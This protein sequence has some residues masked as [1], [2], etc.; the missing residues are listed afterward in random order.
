[1]SFSPGNFDFYA[2]IEPSA[3]DVV[4]HV[5][6]KTLQAQGK[7]L[8]Q[9]TVTVGP[10]TGTIQFEIVKISVPSVGSLNLLDRFAPGN[11]IATFQA[12]AEI[13]FAVSFL[14]VTLNIPNETINVK[15]KDLQI[16]LY[17]AGGFLSGV[18]LG[19]QRF[20][21]D[22]GGLTLLRALNPV[23]NLLADFVALAI[24]TALTPLGMI[25]IPI[26]PLAD[27]YRKIGMLFDANGSPFL[28]T[29]AAGNGLFFA[30][31]F[32]AANNT[33]G[34]I[35]AVQD[36]LPPGGAM[37]VGAVVA[38]RLVNQLFAMLLSTNQVP[39]ALPTP[40]G[41]FRVQW[42]T[43]AF[44][45]PGARASKV[46]LRAK[47][48]ARK[49][50]G[51]GGFIGGLFGL[52]K[53]VT[54][55]LELRLTV[56]AGVVQPAGVPARVDFNFEAIVRGRVTI[57]S[58]LIGVLT[59]LMGPFIAIFLFVLSQIL[60]FFIDFFL[61]F[62]FTYQTTTVPGAPPTKWFHVTIDKLAIQLGL[63]T[64]SLTS[65]TL[66]L[67]ASSTGNGSFELEQFVQHVIATNNV[68]IAVDWSPLGLLTRGSVAGQNE[69]ELFLGAKPRPI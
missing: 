2:Q 29:N 14:G 69:G 63:G 48:T 10:V 45:T 53:K 17:A 7:T 32:Q 51:K 59:V 33:P 42:V 1:M 65:A 31:D 37:N 68:P 21:I 47:A 38:D 9:R 18:A 35:A 3:I 62:T 64:P 55:K 58:V 61:P 60:N 41:T 25:P 40:L 57:D 39:N 23:L 15:V 66:K 34:T 24:R 50:T 30:A 36:I 44:L 4:T 12:D 13:R 16:G 56:D 19:F 6:H 20:D 8:F 11:T 28:G 52:T 5:L 27:A 43:A 46:E 67:E 22:V 49:K 26:A 54:Y